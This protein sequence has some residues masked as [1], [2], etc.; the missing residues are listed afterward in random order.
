MKESCVRKAE[1]GGTLPMFSLCC[2]TR[3]EGWFGCVM[4]H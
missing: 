4:E 2:A 3:D 1:R